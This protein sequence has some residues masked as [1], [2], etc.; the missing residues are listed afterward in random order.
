MSTSLLYHGFG[1]RQ[2][3]LIGSEYPAGRIVFRLEQRK[4][5][6]CPVCGSREVVRN[7]V[8][9]R[10]FLHVPIGTKRVMLSWD[11]P[12]V[13][14]ERCEA[15][16]QVK[17]DF[18]E[19][20]R[21]HTKGFERYALDLLKLGTID[22]VAK[23]LGVSWDTVKDI[24]KRYLGKRFG[25]PKL[26]QVKRIAIDEF[27][28]RKGHAYM[29]VVI[30]YD[31]GVI[32]HVAKGKGVASLAEFWPR[33][34][35]SRAK[36]AA[37]SIDMSPAYIAALRENLPEAAIVFDHF[38]VVKLYNDRL[39]LFRQ[40]LWHTTRSDKERRVIKGLRWLLLKNR[41]NLDS[42]RQEA[43]R[44]AEALKINQPL[45]T[46]Y[47]LKEKLQLL[48]SCNSATE[49]QRLLD[50]W[51]AEAKASG[52]EF[53]SDFADT[54]LAHAYGILAYYEHPISS[55]KLEGTNNKIKV[56]KRKA[57]GYRDDEFFTLKLYSLHTQ[58]ASC[59]H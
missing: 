32:I 18:A 38:H 4:G 19:P 12:R 8:T 53:L 3:R 21:Q 49:A 23:H 59:T 35:R 6:R 17:I 13:K 27:S 40:A 41:C 1:I 5:D 50:E 16:R 55:G 36:V 33:V 31:T 34:R 51:V 26:K 48:W 9:H 14:C 25:K 20:K 47:Y 15:I 52:I 22:S 43:E 58:G 56:M 57:Y 54:L 39:S 30:D 11:V 28:V 44:L 29:T 10:E 7:G 2:H 42:E 45:A 46:A 24:E 37:A